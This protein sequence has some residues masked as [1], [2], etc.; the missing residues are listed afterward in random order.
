MVASPQP[1]Q[2][3]RGQPMAGVQAKV[4][5]VL[6][7]VEAA[8]QLADTG[9]VRGNYLSLNSRHNTHIAAG[10]GGPGPF[11]PSNYGPW[12][13]WS[14]RSDWRS[15]PWTAWWGQSACPPTDWPGWTA[16]PW[17]SNAPWTTWSGCTAKTTATSVITTTV[18]GSAVV[19]T[20]FGLQ[21]AAASAQTTGG[22]TGGMPVVTAGLGGVLGAAVLGVVVGL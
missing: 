14:T 11:G 15:E 13:D 1:S 4:L 17:K 21:V 19:T 16:G 7:A 5:G 18:N 10:S 2:P 3:R 22:S 12:S 8:D 6:E 9:A 20:A